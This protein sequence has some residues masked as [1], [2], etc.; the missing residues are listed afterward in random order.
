[1]RSGWPW[2]PACLLARHH[3]HGLGRLVEAG[4]RSEGG[5]A[6]RNRKDDLGGGSNSLFSSK[7]LLG[8][9]LS[10]GKALQVAVGGLPAP[11]TRQRQVMPFGETLILEPQ[12]GGWKHLEPVGVALGVAGLVGERWDP[13]KVGEH[14][15]LR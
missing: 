4:C 7:L 8:E 3:H 1:M 5:S 10:R 2:F 11:A 6:G 13:N 12:Q 9:L 14:G 15:G